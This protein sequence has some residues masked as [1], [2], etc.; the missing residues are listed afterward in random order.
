MS[1]V[2]QIQRNTSGCCA[3]LIRTGIVLVPH[4]TAWTI[5]QAL[6]TSALIPDD[7][8]FVYYLVWDC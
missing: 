4:G 3:V 2:E 5:P 7:A 8:W 1:Y 6:G